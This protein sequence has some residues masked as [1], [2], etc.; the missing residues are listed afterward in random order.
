VV[1]FYD[2]FLTLP[3]E[4]RYLWPPR[5]KLGWFTSACLL[6][7]YLPLFGSMPVVVTYFISVD[8]KVRPIVLV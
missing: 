5:N 7:R 1:L 4:V 8:F 6:N 3:R 2:Y